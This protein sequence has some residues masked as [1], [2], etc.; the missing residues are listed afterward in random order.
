MSIK[1]SDVAVALTSKGFSKTEN[2]G[3]VILQKGAMKL[4]F[5]NKEA[6]NTLHLSGFKVS[7]IPQV[8]EFSPEKRPTGLVHQFLKF[9]DEQ[10][11]EAL[12]LIITAM[13]LNAV[14]PI[15]STRVGGS[16]TAA[17]ALGFVL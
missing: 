13:E 17:P 11:L 16:K 4:I 2:K 12:R 5:Q 7:D 14:T 10:S 6:C 8:Q 3:W 9:S 1:L 15:I